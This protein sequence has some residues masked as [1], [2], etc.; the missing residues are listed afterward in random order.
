MIKTSEILFFLRNLQLFFIN[1][2]IITVIK[3]QIRD[4]SEYSAQFFSVNIFEFLEY[5]SGVVN[6][7]IDMFRL[8]KWYQNSLSVHPIKTQ[9]ISSGLIWGFGDIAAQTITHSTAQESEQIQAQVK[10]KLPITHYP[11]GF[12]F[13]FL[14]S[15]FW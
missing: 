13:F 11:N 5:S 1:H 4:S 15:I 10:I 8:W 2:R 3:T 14:P 9:V 7:G 6:F 12:F